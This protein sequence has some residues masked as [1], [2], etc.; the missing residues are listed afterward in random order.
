M[1]DDSQKLWSCVGSAGVVNLPDVGKILFN[2]SIAQLGPASPVVVHQV[3]PSALP[4]QT[5]TA[6]IRYGVVPVGGVYIPPMSFLGT[7]L[8]LRYR[9]GDGHVLAKLKQVNIQTGVE[10]PPIVTFDSGS[11]LP[12]SNDFQTQNS[13]ANAVELDFMANAYYVELTLSLTEPRI[14]RPPNYPPAV[15]VIQLCFGQPIIQ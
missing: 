5:I 1:P 14:A 6:I 7:A 8:K 9:G 13:P 4:T 12:A 15:S 11:P 2:Q 3:E 10:T